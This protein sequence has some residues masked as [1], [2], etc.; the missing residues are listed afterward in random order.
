MKFFEFFAV[1]LTACLAVD[2]CDRGWSQQGACTPRLVTDG[3]L[4]WGGDAVARADLLVIGQ[5]QTAGVDALAFTRDPATGDFGSA[6]PL[7]PPVGLSTSTMG[8]IVDTSDRWIAV[9]SRYVS[10][11]DVF[12]R[13]RAGFPFVTSISVATPVSVE[14]TDTWM[15]IGSQRPP[16]SITPGEVLWYEW[17]ELTGWSLRERVQPGIGAPHQPTTGYGCS[18]TSSDPWVA[19]GD[20][21]GSM[22]WNVGNL[23]NGV[24]S[25]YRFTGAGDLEYRGQIPA[26]PTMTTGDAF[27]G[28]V[29]MSE[30]VLAV[31]IIASTVIDVAAP[32]HADTVFVFRE[33]GSGPQPW[34]LSQALTLGGTPFRCNFGHDLAVRHGVVAV[35]TPWYSTY[36]GGGQRSLLHQFRIDP[37][38]DEFFLERVLD[39]QTSAP[40]F[41]W[42]TIWTQVA[43][44]DDLLC[45][46]R[47]VSGPVSRPAAIVFP[48]GST[49]C[50]GNGIADGCELLLATRFDDNR[51][52]WSDVCELA[53]VRYCSP[54][55]ANS[56]GTPARISAFGATTVATI[57]LEL[58]AA[59]LPPAQPGYF[60]A[61]RENRATPMP[62]AWNGVLCVDGAP[63]TRHVGGVLMSSA[64]GRMTA[65]LDLPLLHM[66]A[67]PVPI[68]PGEVW[69]FQAWFRDPGA[70][71]NFSDAVGVRF[72]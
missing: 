43:L 48:P 10:R 46:T 28:V 13:T 21:Q 37:Y 62:G 23:G 33:T 49:D 17:D 8:W 24:V 64:E 26:P 38:T 25:L 29:S 67:G 72:E 16:Y 58:I 50:D 22:Y 35:T 30:D 1:T 18:I 69:Y 34:E 32:Y 4:W 47:T 31:G 9:S 59:G 42:G 41:Q 40:P 56:T 71:S 3:N 7:T 20:H 11:V 15:M 61:S 12:D 5:L 66:P 19:I 52:G 55:P 70:T 14:L 2:E 54:A 39:S 27:G 44:E 57:A 6:I 53:G 65:R 51:N 36:N 60:L 68:L 63:I 45:M